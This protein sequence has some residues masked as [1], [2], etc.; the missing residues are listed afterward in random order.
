MTML[1]GN[2]HGCRTT[3]S[4]MLALDV[5]ALVLATASADLVG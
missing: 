2:G 4:Q 3:A 5:T 1:D